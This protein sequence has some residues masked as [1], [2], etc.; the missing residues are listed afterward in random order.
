MSTT[1]NQFCEL[2][3]EQA[4]DTKPLLDEHLCDYDDL[5][6]NVFLGEITRYVLSD[7]LGRTAIVEFLERQFRQMGPEVEELIAVSFIENI[8]TIYELE[9]ATRG[10]NAV[11][12]KSE[13]RRQRSG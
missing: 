4:P 6:P 10:V 5:L 13:W 1:T 12:L 3:V 7:G 11:E 2:L 9:I 8:E